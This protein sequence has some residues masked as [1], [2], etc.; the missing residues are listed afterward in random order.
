VFKIGFDE[1][2]SSEHR[3]AVLGNPRYAG[4]ALWQLFDTRSYV[5]TGAVRGKP[6]GMNCAGLL[7]EYRRPKLAFHAVRD[8][9]AKAWPGSPPEPSASS[10]RSR[11]PP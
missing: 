5:N 2:T 11:R 3:L 6:R 4:I 10:K 8:L 9:F 7:D 1:G